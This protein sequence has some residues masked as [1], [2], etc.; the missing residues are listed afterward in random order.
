MKLGDQVKKWAPHAACKPCVEHLGEWTKGNRKD[1]KFGKPM[2]R[3][4]PRN[5]ID[6]CYFF[7]VKCGGRDFNS[8][9]RS[10]I[11][12]PNLDSAIRP[13][14]HSDQIEVS[15][16][17][18][19]RDN[20][21][22]DED[23]VGSSSKASAS[24]TSDEEFVS[25]RSDSKARL[26]FSQ[27]DLN[28]LVRDLDLPKNAAKLLASRLHERNLLTSGTKVTFYR[29]REQALLQFFT[30]QNGF[31]YCNDMHG[32]M[33]CVC[34][35]S[36]WRLFI[37]SSMASLKCVFFSNEGK[38]A[39]IPI[40][41]SVFMKESYE[42]MQVVLTKLDYSKHNWV[43]CGDLKVLSMLLGQQEGYTKYPCFLCLWDSRARKE[44]WKRK[45]WP[46]RGEFIVGEKNIMKSPLI[47]PNNVLLPSR[48]IKLGLMKRFVK[49]LNK[50][51]E[52]FAYLCE[53][54]PRLN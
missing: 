45:T 18:N 12:Y 20:S 4:E 50:E 2:V 24:L 44:H 1:L 5:Y 26:P 23:V 10:K 7:I 49:A 15:V 29:Y 19:F 17:T 41:H 3:R 36:E 53:K 47:D 42:T 16:F 43:I 40:G 21:D 13:I 9:T 8:K 30:M 22:E 32:L 35:P 52:C 11:Q 31:V 48:H 38:Y 33:N 51:G 46:E 6:D 37:G 25:S 27:A 34:E 39:S 28:D 14:P 54:F